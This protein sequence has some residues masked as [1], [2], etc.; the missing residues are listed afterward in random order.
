MATK[1]K[2]TKPPAP[3][4]TLRIPDA[5]TRCGSKNFARAKFASG[6]P[7]PPIDRAIAGTIHGFKYQRVVWQRSKCQCGQLIPLRTYH[8]ASQSQPKKR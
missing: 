2:P 5:C 8:A 7:V 1:A 6:E 3:P 4:K